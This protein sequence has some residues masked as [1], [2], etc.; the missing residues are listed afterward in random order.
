MMHLLLL[1]I[2]SLLLWIESWCEKAHDFHFIKIKQ[3]AYITKKKIWR[4]YGRIERSVDAFFMM[5][6]SK[7][8]EK[9]YHRKKTT[10]N[11]VT[12][13]QKLCVNVAQLSFNANCW[14][15]LFHIVTTRTA[16]IYFHFWC[17]CCHRSQNNSVFFF[18]VFYPFCFI[19]ILLSVCNV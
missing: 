3:T 13:S 14:L 10:I 7:L 8:V 2:V 5:K 15:C 17:C 4:K 19:F 11:R 9:K 6:R 18:I 16:S 1:F 12:I